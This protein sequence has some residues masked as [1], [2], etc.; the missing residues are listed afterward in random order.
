MENIIFI[1]SRL[2]KVHGGLTASMLNK[3]KI[4]YENKN[5]K[6]TVLTFHADPNF[7][8]VKGHVIDKYG[9]KESV[10]ILNINEYYRKSNLVSDKKKFEISLE[11]YTKVKINDKNYEFFNQDGRKKFGITLKNKKINE[12]KVFD[13]T[14]NIVEKKLIDNNGYLFSENFYID[15]FLASQTIFRLDQSPYLTRQFDI[16]NRKST[17]TQLVLFNS[18]PIVFNSFDDFKAYFIEQLIE[19]PLTY[20]IVEARGLDNAVMKIED[21]R[22]RKIFMTHSVHIRPDTDIIRAGNRRTLNDLNNVD[23]MVFLTQKQK[24]DVINRFGYRDNYF[25]IPHSISKKKLEHQVI[26]YKVSLISRLHEEKRLEDAIDAFNIVINEVPSATLHIYGEGDERTKLQ[27]RINSFGLQ[28][29]IKLEGHSDEIDKEIQTSECTMLTSKYEGFALVVEESIANGTPVIAYDIKYGPSDMIVDNVN[30]FLVED[31][32]V[33]ELANKIV[34]YLKASEK[35]KEKFQDEALKKSNEFSHVNFIRNWFDLFN[36][37][38]GRKIKFTPHIKFE[39]IKKRRFSDKYIV[40]LKVELESDSNISPN[41]EAKLY[42]RSSLENKE[43][44]KF[45]NLE[46]D[47]KKLDDNI[48]E[49]EIRIDFKKLKPDEIYDLSLSIQYETQ[50]YE[51]RINVKTD[52]GLES[53]KSKK[54]QPYLTEK[55]NN[56]SFKV[57]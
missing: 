27:K 55:H 9:I 7:E 33:K 14:G 8:S 17:I 28:K 3:A 4:F 49:I 39:H 45:Y 5:I 21:S 29:S 16:K 54:V 30:G 31:G 35:E 19:P 10:E 22:V 41:I 11:E 56:L 38:K 48:F 26:P 25:V 13:S 18:T 15:G 42:E 50:F 24:K 6:S 44:K 51:E 23:A 2:D 32:N 46:F 53:L 47:Q 37:I 43:N 36:E 1:T 52:T 20:L 12:V 40:R 57:E 34:S